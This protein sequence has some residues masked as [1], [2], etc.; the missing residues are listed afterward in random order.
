MKIYTVNIQAIVA[1]SN[2]PSEWSMDG[3]I[4][5]I[6][7][8]PKFVVN[9]ESTLLTPSEEVVNTKQEIALVKEEPEFEDSVEHIPFVNEPDGEL[10]VSINGSE[11]TERKSG[12]HLFYDA[13]IK[14]HYSTNKTYRFRRK[15]G[16]VEFVYRSNDYRAKAKKY[17]LGT[18][19][20]VVDRK[21]GDKRP[22]QIVY[23]TKRESR[24]ITEK[25]YR[26]KQELKAKRLRERKQ[27]RARAVKR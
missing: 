8:N 5:Y 2:D 26:I 24:F 18:P 10:I 12:I 9:V 3:L 7:D 1:G 22:R 13:D 19:G 4:E 6:M 27:N 14:E 11:V 15:T 16:E 20:L 21:S 17:N 23:L 25:V